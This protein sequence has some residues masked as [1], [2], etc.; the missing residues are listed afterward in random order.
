MTRVGWRP[1]LVLVI[2]AVAIVLLEED[3]SRWHSWVTYQ[4]LGTFTGCNVMTID[5]V[6]HYACKEGEFDIKW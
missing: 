5:K 3:R 4:H 6:D 2:I 1:L